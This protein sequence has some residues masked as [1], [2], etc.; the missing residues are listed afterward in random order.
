MAKLSRKI[1][2]QVRSILHVSDAKISIQIIKD[3][4]NNEEDSKEPITIKIRNYD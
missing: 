2:E 1:E 4:D 3:S